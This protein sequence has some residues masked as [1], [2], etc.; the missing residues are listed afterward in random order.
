MNKLKETTSDFIRL[1]GDALS[2]ARRRFQN[3][4]H[5]MFFGKPSPFEPVKI[6][7]MAKWVE[8]GEVLISDFPNGFLLI[9]CGSHEVMQHLFLDGP[10]SINVIILQL[11]HWQQFLDPAFF[12]LNTAAIW[13]QLH[14]LPMEFWDGETLESLT[15]YIGNLLTVD[16]L[17]TSLTRSKFAR[18]CIEIVL[19]KP[20]CRGFWIGDDLHKV[21]VTVLYERL[22][23]YYYSCGFMGHG[24]NT[25]PQAEGT[26]RIGVHLPPHD[27]WGKTVISSPGTNAIAQ[28]EGLVD[29]SMTPEEPDTAAEINFGPWMIIGYRKGG[30]RGHIDGS[31]AGHVTPDVSFPNQYNKSE[32]RYS[33]SRGARG[34]M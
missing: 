28:A 15:L 8:I 4:L 10:C 33:A 9:P 21:F 6:F 31:R 22:P 7:L 25:C 23:T 16:N 3:A 24:T 11:S 12:K 2:R 19:F 1:D 26:G 29:S 20:L 18:V 17:T 5:G 34:G 13:V 14:N 32:P 30:A 27:T